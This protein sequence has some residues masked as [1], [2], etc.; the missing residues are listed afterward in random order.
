MTSTRNFIAPVTVLAAA[1]LSSACERPPIDTEQVGYRGTAMVLVE[2]PRAEKNEIAIPEPQPPAPAAGPKAGAVYQNV[3]VLGDLSIAE[4]TRTML[5]ITQWVAPD[6][7]CNYCHYPENLADDGKYTK[8]VSRRMIQMTQHVNREWTDHHGGTGVTCY[9]CH[10]GNNV[11]E[12]IWFKDPSADN[13]KAYTGNRE[14]QNIAGPNV[15]YASLP[16]DPFSRYLEGDKLGNIAV[17]TVG[18]QPTGDTGTIQNTEG[19]YALMFHLSSALGVNCNFCHNS[20][21]FAEWDQSRPQRVTAW[22]GLRMV[23]GLNNEYLNPLQPVY[24]DYRLGPT[25][26]APKANCG[27]CHQGANKPLGGVNM[28]ADYPALQ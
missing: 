25:G 14:G 8:V 17:N 9:T 15:G 5:A 6:E 11:P 18:W 27:T 23:A 12:Y 22:H 10:A 13:M 21:A 28:V 19:T 3:Q 26:D 24:P 4:F 20:R 7:G 1:L 16:T 2:N